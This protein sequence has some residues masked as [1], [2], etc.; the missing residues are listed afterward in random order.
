[1]RSQKMKKISL[2]MKWSLIEFQKSA[3]CL[4]AK[5]H[6]Y[7]P[8][9]LGSRCLLEFGSPTP[10][11]FA[12]MQLGVEYANAFLGA[13]TGNYPFVNNYMTFLRQC[14]VLVNRMSFE[15]KNTLSSCTRCLQ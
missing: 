12:K 5:T 2:M 9:G 14:M 7:D 10:P 6:C 1:M 15:R 4:Q 3:C 8:P 13:V 11:P